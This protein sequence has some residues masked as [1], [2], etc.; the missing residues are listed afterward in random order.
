[1]GFEV[2]NESPDKLITDVT[3][4]AFCFARL[5]GENDTFVYPHM[6]G[7]LVSNPIEKFSSDQIFP[8]AR[9]TMQFRAYYDDSGNGIYCALEDPRGRIKYS[10][11]TGRRKQLFCSWRNPVSYDFG[12]KGGNSYKQSGNAVIEFFS[13]DW[14]NAGQIYKR[15]LSSKAHWWISKLPREDT[16]KWFR[17]NCINILAGVWQGNKTLLY[18]RDYFGMDFG[19]HLVNW[20]PAR[21]WPHFDKATPQTLALLKSLHSAGIRVWPY[22]DPRLWALTDS[23]DMKSDWQ[24]SRLGKTIAVKKE[25]GAVYTEPYGVPCAV[26][27]PATKGG[28]NQIYKCAKKIAEYKFDGM[29]H[30]QLCSRPVMCFDPT[31]GHYANDS[32]FW[33][34]NGYWKIYADLRAKIRKINPDFIHTAEDASDPH[35]KEVDGYMVWRFFDP[36]HVPLFQ[37]IYAGRVQFVGRLFNHQYPGDWNSSFAKVAEQFIYGE[38]LGWITLKDLEVASPLRAYFKN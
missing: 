12:A 30:D 34:E 32:R 36:N 24:Y 15:F 29:Y 22:T 14:F 5:P 37:S 20:T 28:Y 13:G 7:I 17:D 26:I 31:H 8:N 9:N 3:F 6:S 16:P 4:P 2:L 35:L 27:C 25:N 19:V 38:Q 23:E 10:S 1:M 11:D 21:N 33:F 18:L